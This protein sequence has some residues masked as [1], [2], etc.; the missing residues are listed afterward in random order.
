MSTCDDCYEPSYACHCRCIRRRS[1]PNLPE[2]WQPPFNA[3]D[4][5][6]AG[7]AVYSSGVMATE[8]MSANEATFL[9]NLL[10]A[11]YPAKEDSNES[12]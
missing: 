2:G 5:Y 7:W 3:K 12:A 10:N 6:I 9:A 8:Y 11:C 4:S 1:L